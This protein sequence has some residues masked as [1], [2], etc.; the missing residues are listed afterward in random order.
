MTDVMDETVADIL[1]D[2]DDEDVEPKSS[3]FVCHHERDGEVCGK[4]FPGLSNLNAHM[5][6]VHFVTHDGKP[7]KP[8]GRRIG[9]PRRKGEDDAPSTKTSQPKTERKA[10]SKS[11]GHAGPSITDSNRA[12]IYGQSLATVGLLAHLAAGRWFDDYD[13]N[14]WTTGS[15]PL[16]NALDAVGEQNPGLRR[17]CDMLLAGGTGGA[18]VQ[19]I[20]ASAMIAVPIAAHHNLLP[21]ATGERFGA[22]LGVMA[23]QAGQ[24]P[25]SGATVPQ[26]DADAAPPTTTLPV[27]E[28]TMDEW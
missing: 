19:L 12:A 13:L 14:V 18:Y 25:E 4:S 5:M 15:Q 11:T 27:S 22:M 6:R 23:P 24:T 16:A 20:L 21:A 9:S 1:G 8:S 2:N 26:P 3:L 17:T 28:W 7:V 10:A